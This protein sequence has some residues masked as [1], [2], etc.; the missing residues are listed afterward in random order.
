MAFFFPCSKAMG[1]LLELVGSNVLMERSKKKTTGRQEGD[2]VL[3]NCS[4]RPARKVDPGLRAACE[5]SRKSR[6]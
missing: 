5:Q 1:E 2:R 4:P 3:M 6:E